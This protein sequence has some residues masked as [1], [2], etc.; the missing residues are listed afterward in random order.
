MRAMRLHRNASQLRADQ[1]PTPEPGAGEVLVKVAFCGVCR[2]DLHILDGELQPPKWPVTPG[3]EVIGTVEALGEGVT[4]LETGQAVG[5]PW[6]GQTCGDCHWC[7]GGRENLCEQASFT[8][9][10]RPGGYAEYLCAQRDFC[11]PLPAGL[12]GPEAAPLLCAGLIGYRTLRLAGDNLR[13]IG[14]YGFG[15]AAH[16]VAQIA[17]ARNIEVYAYTRP[18]DTRGQAFARKIGCQWAGGTDTPPPA[19]LDAALI[20]APAGE[21]VPLALKHLDRGGTVVCG[22][23]HMSP[24]P[25]FD[26]ADLWQE[27]SI[28]SVANLSR[29]DGEELLEIAAELQ[30]KP[31]VTTYPLMEANQALEDLRQGRFDGAA[32]LEI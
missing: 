23:I 9:Y 8:G 5:V 30:L 22:G 32:V 29:R 19:P 13:R 24:I 26:Y 11:F 1:L 16:L 18:G 25:Q 6:L 12:S 2:T 27:R 28:R 31:T 3:H 7:R 14:I 21:L 10:S 15:A 4:D 17:I 20:F